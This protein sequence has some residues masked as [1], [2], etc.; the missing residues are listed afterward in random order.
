MSKIWSAF[1]WSFKRTF[2]ALF[3][4]VTKLWFE[5]LPIEW[6]W[7]GLRVNILN[8]VDKFPQ[9]NLFRFPRKMNFKRIVHFWWET[10]CL[11]KLWP[12]GRLTAGLEVF[13]ARRLRLDIEINQTVRCSYDL[14]VKSEFQ[15][16]KHK[17]GTLSC[18]SPLKDLQWTFTPR[19]S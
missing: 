7:I 11:F 2:G 17:Y 9:W 3:T 16:I 19:T 8:P 13:D 6:V 12:I 4:Q 5:S 1:D 10:F 15:V 14:D 18:S